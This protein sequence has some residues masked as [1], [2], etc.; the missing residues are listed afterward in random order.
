MLGSVSLSPP[1]TG[2]RGLG[3]VQVRVFPAGLCWLGVCTALQRDLGSRASP[4]SRVYL[5]ANDI[6][7]LEP[8]GASCWVITFCKCFKHKIF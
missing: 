1:E 2:A 4:L 5:E 8:Q 6:E 3:G 7:D